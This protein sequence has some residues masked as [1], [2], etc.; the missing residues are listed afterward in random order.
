MGE[1]GSIG[2]AS[3]VEELE[4]GA[5]EEELERGSFVKSVSGK[6]RGGDCGEHLDGVGRVGSRDSGDGEVGS[7]VEGE[8]L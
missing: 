4:T 3:V 5:L 8:A 1:A 6:G 2:E 7:P